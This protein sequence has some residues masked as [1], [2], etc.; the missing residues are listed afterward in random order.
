VLERRAQE[1]ILLPLDRQV[2]HERHQRPDRAVLGSSVDGA[3]AR[4]GP[5]VRRHASF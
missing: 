1:A 4:A 2:V 3:G 5:A